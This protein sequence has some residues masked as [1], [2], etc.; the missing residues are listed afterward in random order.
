[1]A[2]PRKSID[3]YKKELLDKV[4]NNKDL[5]I[6]KCNDDKQYSNY[7][8]CFTCRQGEYFNVESKAC[9]ICNGTM[10]TTTSTCIPKSTLVTN[11]TTATN[12]ILPD[13][14]TLK[15]YTDEQKLIQG[16]V[17][18]CPK[19]KPYAVT[20][21]SCIAC[22]E[23]T[24]Y[25]NLKDQKCQACQ[26][27]SFYNSK[28]LICEDGVFVS[29]VPALTKYVQV[30]NYT[31]AN[32][33]KQISE[34][35]KTK[36]IIE[37]PAATPFY[38]GKKCN[39][40]SNTTYVNLKTFECISPVVVANVQVL[41]QLDN[42]FEEGNSTILSLNASIAKITLPKAVCP[43]AKPAYNGKECYSC[44]EDKYYNLKTNECVEGV[45]VTNVESLKKLKNFKE[46]DNY[47]L[48]NI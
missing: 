10:N 4:Q 46:T 17:E 20:G 14:K 26:P 47:T 37:C 15:D 25:F 30:E 27:N 36:P 33:K 35:N 18:A 1:M 2:T 12:L 13:K 44:P 29:N 24:K 23:A 21:T 38:D 9:S 11:L 43:E 48:A 6:N 16:P 5:I 34:I 28:L 42:V 3:E 41:D 31:I 19:D 39:A 45:T 8:A 7:T 32:I 22:P 40:C